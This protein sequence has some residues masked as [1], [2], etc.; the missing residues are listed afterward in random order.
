[1]TSPAERRIPDFYKRVRRIEPAPAEIQPEWTR[2]EVIGIAKVTCGFCH[3]YGLVPVLR[4]AAV[5]CRC[6]FRAIFRICHARYRE[7]EAMVT[8]T[9]GVGIERAGGPSGYRLYSRKRQE[10]TA[11][12]ALVAHRSLDPEEY[13]VFRLHFLGCADWRACCHT[14]GLDRGTFFHRVY[15]LTERLGRIFA[16][17]RPYPLYPVSTYFGGVVQSPETLPLEIDAEVA[18]SPILRRGPQAEFAQR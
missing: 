15:S 16:E 1:M 5:P 7:C 12:F 4:G 9:N 8:H 18:G 13:G 2:S 11:D 3:G 17:L 14:L 6:V 10:Y